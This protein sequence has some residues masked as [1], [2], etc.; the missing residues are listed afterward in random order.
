MALVA[1]TTFGLGHFDRVRAAISSEQQLLGD[2]DGQGY[3]LIVQSYAPAAV[4]DSG[5]PSAHARPLG[6]VQ[7]AVT[8]EELAR[9]IEID[10][11]QVGGE[12][13][14]EGS[15]FVLAWVER[16]QPD[17]EFDARRARPTHD[18]MIGSSLVPGESA[19]AARVVLRRRA[20]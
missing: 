7:R 2:D 3:R 6:S 11:V 16:G 9:G 20:A 18:A 15:P 8:A 19:D 14:V 5:L 4:N 10:V 13:T 1:A 12:A 17:L